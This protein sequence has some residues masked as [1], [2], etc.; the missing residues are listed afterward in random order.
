LIFENVG[1]LA[2]LDSIRAKAAEDV[3]VALSPPKLRS[4]P[5]TPSEKYT[6]SKSF[7][8]PL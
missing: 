2:T 5:R 4:V 7:A 1:A 3:V 6:G 8:L